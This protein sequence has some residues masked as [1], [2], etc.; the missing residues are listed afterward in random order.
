MVIRKCKHPKIL[1]LST[2]HTSAFLPYPTP[3]MTSGLIQYGV[4]VTDLIP[5]TKLAIV[6]NRRDAPK[7]ASF[8]FPEPAL[9]I[10]APGVRE[11]QMFNTKPVHAW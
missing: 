11:S 6:C 5:V 8:T 7:S 4:P 3:F 2:H 10:F 1:Q 9:K